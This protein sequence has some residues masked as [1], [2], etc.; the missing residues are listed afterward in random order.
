MVFALTLRSFTSTLLP[1]STIGTCSQ[2]RTRSPVG[3]VTL[4]LDAVEF[5]ILT[6][7]VWHVLVGD[8]RCDVKHDDAALA[9]DVVAI[10]QPTKLLLPC[11]IPDIELDT[12]VVLWLCGISKGMRR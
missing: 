8:T 5:G 7:P 1:H 10:S 12:S 4:A 3:F 2:T 6:M 11:C 9:V